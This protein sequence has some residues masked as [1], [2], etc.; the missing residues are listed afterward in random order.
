MITRISRKLREEADEAEARGD[1]R[2]SGTMREA[3]MEIEHMGE[4][5]RVCARLSKSERLMSIPRARV[6]GFAALVVAALAMIAVLAL[7][8]YGAQH[9]LQTMVM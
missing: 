9:V 6:V 8:L 1:A 2:T 4:M 7:A 5:L 3:A